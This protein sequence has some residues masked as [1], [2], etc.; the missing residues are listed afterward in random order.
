M[1]LDILRKFFAGTVDV[2]SPSDIF[3][4][5][6]VPELLVHGGIYEDQQGRHRVKKELVAIP[7]KQDPQLWMSI[8]PDT[9][10]MDPVFD[11]PHTNLYM[12]GIDDG[13]MVVMV[14]WLAEQWEQQRDA[15]ILVYKTT[16]V[17][18]VHRLASIKT[19]GHKRL[20]YFKGDNNWSKDPE[21]AGDEGIEWLLAGTIY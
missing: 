20:W 17:Y 1:W 3:L 9:N 8:I 10:S 19:V 2:P 18:A 13:D 21:P 15:N 6:E 16:S 5:K 7:F 12:R 11:S 14:D 4:S